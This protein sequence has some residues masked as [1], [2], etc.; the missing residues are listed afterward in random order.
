MG[1]WGDDL[2]GYCKMQVIFRLINEI[3]IKNMVSVGTQ[4]KLIPFFL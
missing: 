4:D 3:Q 1:H 2:K